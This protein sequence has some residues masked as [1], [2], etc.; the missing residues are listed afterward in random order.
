MSNTAVKLR[1]DPLPR[2]E[3]VKL[4]ISLS[5]EVKAALDRYLHRF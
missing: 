5:T 2:S 3:V 1:L 4:T